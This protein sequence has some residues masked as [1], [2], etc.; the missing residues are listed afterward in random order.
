MGRFQR[1]SAGGAALVVSVLALAAALVGTAFSAGG[2]QVPGKNGVLSSDIK[3][4]QVKG[5]DLSKIVTHSTDGT[6]EGT[7]DNEN[8]GVEEV[9]VNCE[10]KEKVIGGG[11][12]FPDETSPGIQNTHDNFVGE[13]FK[14]G[15]GWTIDAV[16]DEE[17]EDFIAYAYCVK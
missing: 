17:P 9:T 13:S 1:P 5:K 10:G 8:Y 11:L 16:S 14:D 3:N 15:N 12:T 4:K 7:A 6:I 2:S